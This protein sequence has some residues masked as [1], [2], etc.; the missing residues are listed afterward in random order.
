M[1]KNQRYARNIKIDEEQDD[2][3]IDSDCSIIYEDYN[4]K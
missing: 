4:T 3:K 1:L 2:S